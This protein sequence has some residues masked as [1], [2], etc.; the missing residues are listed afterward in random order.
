MENLPGNLTDI[1]TN[2]GSKSMKSDCSIKETTQ[3]YQLEYQYD[4]WILQECDFD[5]CLKS[6]G[7]DIW[8]LPRNIFVEEKI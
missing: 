2:S 7:S 4:Y 3:H 5:V 8:S 6:N 1:G